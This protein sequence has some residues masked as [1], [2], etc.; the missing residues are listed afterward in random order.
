MGMPVL[1]IAA[2]VVCDNM[3]RILSLKYLVLCCVIVLVLD[4]H[5]NICAAAVA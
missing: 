4:K 1:S 5:C 2:A 3:A